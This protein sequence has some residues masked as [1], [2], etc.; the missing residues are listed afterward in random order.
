MQDPEGMQAAPSGIS[1]FEWVL[2]E[3]GLHGYVSAALRLACIKACRSDASYKKKDVQEK[4]GYIFSE[5][6]MNFSAI[7]LLHIMTILKDWDL[8]CNSFPLGD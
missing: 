1:P 8:L 6:L 3:L 5:I 4:R 2:H 7:S